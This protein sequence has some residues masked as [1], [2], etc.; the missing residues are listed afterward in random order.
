MCNEKHIAGK[1]ITPDRRCVVELTSQ[2][3]KALRKLI[4]TGRAAAYKPRHARV[5][6]LADEKS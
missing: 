6:P 2:E 3:R 4:S 1:L 5:L